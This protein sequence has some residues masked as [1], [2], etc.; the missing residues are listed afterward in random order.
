MFEILQGFGDNV[1]L[2]IKNPSNETEQ[3][4]PPASFQQ[5]LKRNLNIPGLVLTDHKKSYTNK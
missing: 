4:L 3:P 2:S 1:S 5:F